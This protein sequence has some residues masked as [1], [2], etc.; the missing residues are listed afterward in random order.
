MVRN[1]RFED[2]KIRIDPYSMQAQTPQTKLSSI[3][4]FLQTLYLPLAQ[5]AQQ[6]GI[7]IDLHALFDKA[8]KYM[9]MPDLSDILTTQDPPSQDVSS[10]GQGEGGGPPPGKPNQTTRTYERRSIGN[11]PSSQ[12]QQLQQKLGSQK[13]GSNGVHQPAGA[14]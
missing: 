2:M 12:G 14:A 9:D 13:V 7:T 6:Q 1:H 3:M 10:G 5:M 11:S 4:Q 8:G